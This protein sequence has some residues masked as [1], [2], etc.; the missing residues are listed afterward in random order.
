MHSG[1]AV[2]AVATVPPEAC[3]PLPADAMG[4]ASIELPERQMR[5]L[6]AEA[7]VM[8]RMRHPK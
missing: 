1:A 7:A 8:A 3:L 5:A 6:Q 2:P 4:R